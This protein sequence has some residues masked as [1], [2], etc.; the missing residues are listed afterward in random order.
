[1]CGFSGKSLRSF[2]VIA[3]L[4]LA[5]SPCF[6]GW[7]K[8]AKT[9]AP[10]SGPTKVEAKAE[11]PSTV[12][13]TET[14]PSERNASAESPRT[15]ADTSTLGSTVRVPKETLATWADTM[16]AAAKDMRAFHFGFGT[17]ATYNIDDGVGIDL[18]GT[19]RHDSV[20]LLYG[21]TYYPDKDFDAGDFTYHAGLFVEF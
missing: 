18:F 16:D 12:P 7:L 3:G 19:V 20:G 8:P 17:G 6:A 9:E 15:Y 10:V 4:C 11:A 21:V 1:M 13:S 5:A 2:F 14:A